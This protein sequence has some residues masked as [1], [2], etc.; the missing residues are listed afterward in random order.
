MRRFAPQIATPGPIL[1]RD[2]KELGRHEGL[3]YYTIGQRKGLGV[4][5][6][7]PLYVL[8]KQRDT[9]ALVVGQVQELGSSECRVSGINWIA[10]EP[11]AGPLRAEVKTR[12]TAREV[13]AEIR[14]GGAPSEATLSFEVPVRDITPGQ[15][16]VF[17]S[18]D[19][20]LG[21]GTIIP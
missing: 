18:G 15:A 3:A 17:Y 20:V 4:T 9:N 7:V 6:P 13:W 12:Y 11:P 5:S 10:G 2:G 21:G 19:L 16:A 8:S 1:T 14:P